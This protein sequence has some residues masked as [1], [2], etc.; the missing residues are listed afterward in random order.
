M[1][2]KVLGHKQARATEGNAHL[3][4]DPLRVVVD[5]TA[6]RIA[7]AMMGSRGRDQIIPFIGS[8]IVK[9]VGSEQASLESCRLRLE[10]QL[11]GVVADDADIAFRETGGCLAERPRK[12]RMASTA[13]KADRPVQCTV[14]SAAPPA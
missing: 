13:S 3:A 4:A 8:E 11:A 14:T 6:A 12:S 10:F 9:E 5:G 2:G 7:M 1:V